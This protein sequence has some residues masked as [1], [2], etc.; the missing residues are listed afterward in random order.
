MIIR[1]FIIIIILFVYIHIYIHLH[2]SK[3]NELNTL[4]DINHNE[5]T[6]QIYYK[7]PFFF[8]AEH[9]EHNVDISQCLIENDYLIKPYETYKLLEP[10]VKFFNTNVIY[11]NNKHYLHYNLHCRTFYKC[12]NKPIDFIIIHPKYKDNFNELKDGCYETND[13]IISYIKNSKNFINI[14]IQKDE[15]LF[16]PNYWIVYFELCENK[17]EKIQ[18]STILNQFSFLFYKLAFYNKIKD[19]YK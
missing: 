4:Y 13:K 2:V 14:T 16:I 5:I 10:S 6:N 8:K 9:I 17:I 3:Y 11:H 18:Y 19:F 1:L 15:I 12:L 7:L